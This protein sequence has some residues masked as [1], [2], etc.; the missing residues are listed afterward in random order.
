[1]F[2][3]PAEYL[4]VQIDSPRQV[5]CPP[6]NPFAA[7][8]GGSAKIFSQRAGLSTSQLQKGFIN[9]VDLGFDALHCALIEDMS[10]RL[11]SL[12]YTS[13]QRVVMTGIFT[14]SVLFAHKCSGGRRRGR[15]GVANRVGDSALGLRI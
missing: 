3:A 12:A 15:S 4:F 1:M 5:V 13:R 9:H 6:P 2:F 10:I 7:C 8:I 14:S 11:I